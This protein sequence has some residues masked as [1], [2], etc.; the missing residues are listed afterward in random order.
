M[1]DLYKLKDSLVKELEDLGRMGL[2][3]SNL[4]TVDKLAH[5]AKNLAKVIECCENDEYSNGYS[6]RM[7]YADEGYSADL[8]KPYVRPDGSYRDGG[9]S[10]ARGRR[11]A[12]RDAMGRY[13]GDGGMD[14][15]TKE[16]LMRM[17][18]NM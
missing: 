1:R 7:S 11:N 6:R 15:K 8:A 5:A 13:S 4:D 3:K 12:P 10:H 9:M 2:S 17:I 14:E 16:D 18:E